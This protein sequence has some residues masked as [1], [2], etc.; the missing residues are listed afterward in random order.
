MMKIKN[1]NIFSM[2]EKTFKNLIA[3]KAILFMMIIYPVLAIIFRFMF[4]LEKYIEPLNSFFVMNITMIPILIMSSIIAEEKEKGIIK[5]LILS[6]ISSIEYLIGT[7]FCVLIGVT[8]SSM[9]YS[10]LLLPNKIYGDMTYFLITILAAMPSILLGCI[11]GMKTNSQVEVGAKAAPI[12]MAV[13]MVPMFKGSNVF[14]DHVINKIYSSVIFDY[15][16]GKVQ[17]E[18]LTSIVIVFANILILSFL[19][20]IVYKNSKLDR[21]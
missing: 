7:T 1:S 10:I 21:N 18:N 19:F 16:G 3:N 11:I 14:A 5:Y 20:S 4:P 9:S 15:M 8:I 13:G 17:V 2:I 6:G 12:A